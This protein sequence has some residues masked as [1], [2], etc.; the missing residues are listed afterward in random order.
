MKHSALLNR[1]QPYVLYLKGQV[2]TSEGKVGKVQEGN[3]LN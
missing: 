2:K 1:F 3:K